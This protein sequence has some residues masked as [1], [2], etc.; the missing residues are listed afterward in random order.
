MINFFKKLF[1][2]KKNP[3]CDCEVD[4]GAKI[5]FFK[6]SVRLNKP[7]KTRMDRILKPFQEWPWTEINKGNTVCTTEDGKFLYVQKPDGTKIY[8]PES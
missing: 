4:C 1:K 3:L 6:Y 2:P 5:E 7:C 8:E